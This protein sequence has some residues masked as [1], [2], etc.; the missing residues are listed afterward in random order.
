M[1]GGLVQAAGR[2]RESEMKTKSVRWAALAATVG[3]AAAAYAGDGRDAGSDPGVVTEWNQILESVV[4]AGGLTPP[5]YYSMLHVAMFDAVNSIS[6]DHRPF[7]TRVW[8]PRGA[9]L[10]AAA[11]QAAHDVLAAQFPASVGVFDAALQARL[12]G[13]PTGRAKLGVE[14]GQAVA[15]EILEWR[16]HD[17]WNDPVPAYV[18]PALPGLYQPTPPAFGPAQFVQFGSTTPFALLTPTLYLP[19]APPTLTSERYA[20][21]F[22]EVK[23]VGSTTSTVRTPE[24]TQ[25]ARLFAS[26]ISSTVHWAL[27][28]HVARD[29]AQEKHLSLVE[30]ARLFALL[31]V[32]IHDGVQT[33][34]TSKFIYGLWRPVTAIRR[35]D[36]DL[37]PATTAD[38]G[39][40]PLLTTPP[41]PSYS[42][43]MAC[44]GSSAARALGLF[45]G[46]DE[47]AFTARWVGSGGN[48]DVARSYATFSAM[49]LDQANSRIFGGIHYRFDNDASRAT[50]PRVAD[51]V[52][53]NYMRPLRR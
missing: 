2:P 36:E 29:T 52:F 20:T 38:A 41:Y 12:A 11:A 49:A 3:L 26:V 42:G 43:N 10:E 51:Y 50:C 17:G 48:P 53:T 33:S 23:A 34:H 25:L 16:A 7:H 45:Y 18:L 8:A 27:W 37:N 6:G 9:S 28:N 22:E 30:S 4:P 13:I 39:W 14:V 46:T 19:V 44:V 32:S 1:A 24:Q 5:R 21:D 40:T 31:N 47:M 35:A 15:A